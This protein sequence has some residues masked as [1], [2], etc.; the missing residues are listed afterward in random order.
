MAQQTTE[1]VDRDNTNVNWR[2]DL[3][4]YLDDQMRHRGW[5]SLDLA[6]KAG[7]STSSVSRATGKG[8]RAEQNPPSLSVLVRI[9]DA[10]GVP[11]VNILRLA[12][13]IELEPQQTSETRELVMMYERLPRE[14]QETLM[15]VA[16]S[17]YGHKSG[18][19]DD[20]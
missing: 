4:K 14:H 8:Q 7:M 17:I 2:A 5:T 20:G 18:L 10:L 16:R 15:F 6:E 12:G 3:S 9:A 11:D 1:R 13:L 19:F